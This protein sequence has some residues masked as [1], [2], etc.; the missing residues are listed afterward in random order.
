MVLLVD[1]SSSDEP[2]FAQRVREK[3]IFRRSKTGRLSSV[4]IFAF[5]GPKPIGIAGF[6]PLREFS[7]QKID[8]ELLV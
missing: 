4:H 7:H 1:V 8:S 5:Y 6:L 2:D 3:Q